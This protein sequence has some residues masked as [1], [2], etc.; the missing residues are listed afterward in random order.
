M[1]PNARP[2][3][4]RPTCSWDSA[5]CCWAWSPCHSSLARSCPTYPPMAHLPH[6]NTATD[7]CSARHALSYPSHSCSSLDLSN[8]AQASLASV[9]FSNIPSA[10]YS[11]HSR[12]FSSARHSCFGSHTPLPPSLSHSD[13]PYL[14]SA[15]RRLNNS[16]IH[17]T[18]SP[19]FSLHYLPSSSHRY[20]RNSSSAACSKT[21]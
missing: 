19:L 20:S 12:R 1:H 6:A 9:S 17:P 7:P 5:S 14:R 8:T 3:L 16:P 4:T 21:P 2:A 13:K 18:P 11:P 15:T 10:T